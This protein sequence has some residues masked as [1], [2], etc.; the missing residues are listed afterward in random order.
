[1]GLMERQHVWDHPASMWCV[2]SSLKVAFVGKTLSFSIL[3]GNSP[4]NII[5]WPNIF[6][7]EAVSIEVCTYT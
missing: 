7:P 2:D 6:V 5:A 3:A 1:M 4:Q